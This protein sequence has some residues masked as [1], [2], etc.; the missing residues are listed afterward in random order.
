MPQ[1]CSFGMSGVILCPLLNFP[2]SQNICS[3]FC[4]FLFVG[5]IGPSVKSN[6]EDIVL[7][8]PKNRFDDTL[9]LMF[10]KVFLK[11]FS[12]V[13]S[14][15]A[16]HSTAEIFSHCKAFERLSTNKQTLRAKLMPQ[17]KQNSVIWLLCLIILD[18]TSQCK[19]LASRGLKDHTMTESFLQKSCCLYCPLCY[20]QLQQ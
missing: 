7:I 4:N 16:F 3:K 13:F 2:L 14:A 5:R 10:S 6:F 18:P 12:G 9:S 1:K 11:M 20:A 15:V 19:L 17:K 8:L